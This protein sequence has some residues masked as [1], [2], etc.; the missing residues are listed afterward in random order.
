MF[1]FRKILVPTDFSEQF[2]IALNYAKELVK[3]GEDTELHIIHVIEHSVYP[4]DLGI[5]QASFIDLE[6]EMNKKSVE[7]LEFIKQ[8]LEREGI[9]PVIHINTGRASDRIIEYANLQKID[10]ICIAT[11]GRSGLEHFLFGS[12][13]EKVIRK[14]PC[15]VLAVRMPTNK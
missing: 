3:S 11:H 5:T 14:A 6:K 9:Q 15:P 8:D 2:I 1:K 10:L 4:A 12:T 13:A 7:Q